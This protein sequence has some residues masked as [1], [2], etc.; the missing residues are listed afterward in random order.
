M[1]PLRFLR[2]RRILYLLVLCL[3]VLGC[4]TALK[5]LS[6]SEAEEESK[7]KHELFNKPELE[8]TVT[9]RV[10]AV[11]SEADHDAHKVEDK[12]IKE[13]NQIFP[14][15]SETKQ[16]TANS[17]NEEPDSSL[18]EPNYNIHIFYYAWYGNPEHD[19]RYVHW[20]HQYLPHW[21][22][23]IAK[24][25]Q[26]GYHSPPDDIGSNFYPALGPYSSKDPKVI[27]EHMRQMRTAG[28]GVI[29][30]SWYPPGRA[31]SEGI[32]SDGLVPSLLNAA[33][34]YRLKVTLH[35]EPYKGRD[36][37][38]VHSDV[39]YI[40]DTYGKHEAF[41]KYQT[42]DGRSLPMLYIYD[43]YHTPAEAWAQLMTTDGSHSV[44][45]TPY[46]CIFIA[47]MVEMNH[48]KYI[49][50]GGFD[51]FY[52]YFATDKFTYG[53]TWRFWPQLKSIA[54]QTNTLFIPSV[55]PGYIDTAVRP[56]NSANM[57]LRNGG[58]YY[59]NSWKAALQTSPHIISITSFNEWHEGTQIEKA[60]PKWSSG[61]FYK[62]YSPNAADFYL[63]LTKEF[64]EKFA[65]VHE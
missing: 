64:V 6:S 34:K 17:L 52:T 63:K 47:L 43:S 37:K 48:R 33:A 2:K 30:L 38:T 42:A 8:E 26:K 11:P 4:F 55:G 65:A 15:E 25:Y 60:I 40:I 51:G 32:P 23:D 10:S 41:Y 61:L 53:S 59:R 57:R 9:G 21:N 45:N 39:K 31:D 54:E 14:N 62:D 29:A 12:E 1:S 5:I 44:R 27:D 35:I 58:N 18:P 22:P 3:F 56:W 28:V 36:D 49:D 50:T 24:Q 13:D 46:D 7:P 19:G 16:L 20:N